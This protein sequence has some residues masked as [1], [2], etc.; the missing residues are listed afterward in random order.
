MVPGLSDEGSRMKINF[1]VTNV[2]KPLIAVSKLMAAV[3]DVWFGQQHGVIT[4]GETGKQTTF[5]KK[6]GCT[7][8]ESGLRALGLLL[9]PRRRGASGSEQSSHKTVS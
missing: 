3:H 2:D 4:H 6:N 9:P 5:M 1:Q 7:Y 8:C